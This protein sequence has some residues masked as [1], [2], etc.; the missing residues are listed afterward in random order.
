MRVSASWR[1]D[2]KSA[3]TFGGLTRIDHGA[4]IPSMMMR[5]HG[6]AEQCA[7]LQLSVRRS[8]SAVGQRRPFRCFIGVRGDSSESQRTPRGERRHWSLVRQSRPLAAGQASAKKERLDGG[9]VSRAFGAGC[10]YAAGLAAIRRRA[11]AERW[12]AEEWDA[13][14]E[15]DRLRRRAKNASR[16]RATKTSRSLGGLLA[17]QRA[18]RVE[19]DTGYPMVV[20]TLGP[21]FLRIRGVMVTAREKTKK[22]MTLRLTADQNEQIEALALVLGVDKTELLLRA[23]DRFAEE[24]RRDPEFE[25]LRAAALERQQ[26][27]LES[28]GHARPL[29]S[30]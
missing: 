29:A 13:L 27:L 21:F 8:L 10:F 16:H 9:L 11:I 26:K 23:V 25:K 14:R 22:A 4:R 18:T 20:D 15:L 30:R 1:L 28:L 17:R 3:S 6:V 12:A 24:T 19:G 2:G 5:T 7:L